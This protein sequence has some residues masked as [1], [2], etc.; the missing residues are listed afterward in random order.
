M[1]DDTKIMLLRRALEQNP[2]SAKFTLALANLVADNDG[3]DEYARLF[4]QAY[5][6]DP[7]AS[8]LDLG[9]AGIAVDQASKLRSKAEALLERNV[10][11]SAVIAA[12][13]ISSA[14]LGDDKTVEGLIDYNRFFS[15]T[16]NVVPREFDER[17]FFA[18]LASEIRGKLEFYDS[19][20]DK[21][22][23]KAWRHNDIL[24]SDGAACRALAREIR[25]RVEQYISGLAAAT[26]HPFLASIPAKFDIAG[27][28]VVSGSGGHHKSHIHPRAWASGVYYVVRPDIS[29]Q[30]DAHRGWLR[31]G[32][33]PLDGV[34]SS[35]GWPTRM[36]A[37]EPGTLVLMPGYFFHDTDPMD[38]D[39][40]RICIAF[41]VEPVEPAAI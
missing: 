13:A 15:V 8:L 27:W 5:T 37:P 4:R 35:A 18:T 31:V 34:S 24:N 21:S 22:I 20:D 10:C 16:S 41:D 39:Q 40:E 30:A 1:R 23:R 3:Y 19:P 12:L 25:A 36:I 7:M 9:S 6:I 28:A 38:I 11:Y 17:R 29:R 2:R 26:N 14:S 33:P 32:P